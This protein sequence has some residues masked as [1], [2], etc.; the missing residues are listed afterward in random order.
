MIFEQN[1]DK[2]FDARMKTQTH[3]FSHTKRAHILHEKNEREL[4]KEQVCERH[5]AVEYIEFTCL[6]L[7]IL[8]QF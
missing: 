1:D 6:S 8:A 5:V 7:F 4:E 3:T 2:R